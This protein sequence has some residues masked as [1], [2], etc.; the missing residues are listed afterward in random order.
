[1]PLLTFEQAI[2]DSADCSKRHLILGNG[3]SIACRA[4]IFH[5][6]SLYQQADFS[7]I[8]EARL[9]FEAL[10]TQDFELAIH[11]L[12]NGAKILPIYAPNHAETAQAMLAH[13]DAL[14]ELLFP[15]IT[16]DVRGPF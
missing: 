3:F 15:T 16:K 9:V 11:A 5:Y 14:K 10:H 4:D 12:E 6:A 13:A 1:M 2:A 7:D 8:P